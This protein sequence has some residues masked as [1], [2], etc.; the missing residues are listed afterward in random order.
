MIKKPVDQYKPEEL[1][2]VD[3]SMPEQEITLRAYRDENK[4]TVWVTDNVALTKMKKLMAKAPDRCK[5]RKI[6]WTREGRPFSY[7]FEVDK[8]CVRI[9]VPR[10]YSEEQKAKLAERL[11]R[12]NKS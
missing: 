11:K 4:F 7:E 9:G 3:A 6:V 1:E 5:L 2:V 8:K 10:E 12:M